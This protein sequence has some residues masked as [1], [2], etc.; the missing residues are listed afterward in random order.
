MTV[1]ELNDVMIHWQD[2]KYRDYEIAVWDWRRQKEMNLVFTG[3][4]HPERE[5]NFNVTDKNETEW[6]MPGDAYSMPRELPSPFVEGKKALLQEDP[7]YSFGG[8]VYTRYF[9]RCEETE[10]C[11]TTD[12]SDTYSMCNYYR[13]KCKKLQEELKHAIQH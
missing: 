12:I 11:F 6:L 4:S 9:Y 5:V 8:I 10:K 13:E 7:N 1:R 2:S 3:C